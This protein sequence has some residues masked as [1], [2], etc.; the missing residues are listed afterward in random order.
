MT[1]QEE[2]Q[3]LL[4]RSVAH[5]RKQGRKSLA[6]LVAGAQ[7][8]CAYRTPE[9]LQCAAGPFINE[10]HPGMEC[11]GFDTLCVQYEDCVDPAAFKHYHFVR[12]VLQYSHDMVGEEGGFIQN[13]EKKLAERAAWWNGNH[14]LAPITIP[15]S[16][17]DA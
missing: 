17:V 10:Y 15:P 2:V 8:G 13:Y 7:P 6:Q 5:V 12:D 11:K 1:E 14:P 4:N 16:T 3:D 9:G